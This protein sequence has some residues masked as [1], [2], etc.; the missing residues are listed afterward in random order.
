MG[1]KCVNEIAELEKLADNRAEEV[2]VKDKINY[3]LPISRE[4]VAEYSR[5]LSQLKA[6]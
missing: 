4:S 2:T 1:V 6:L 5:I 3:V